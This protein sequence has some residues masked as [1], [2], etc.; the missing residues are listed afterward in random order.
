MG[1]FFSSLFNWYSQKEIE[2]AIIG[3]ENCGKT[4]LATQLQLNHVPS[5]ERIP[6]MTMNYKL[7]RRGHVLVKMMDLPGHR[8]C[9]QQWVNL[10][11]CCHA[12]IFMVD[13]TLLDHEESIEALK[14]VLPLLRSQSLPLL[15]V[16]NKVDLSSSVPLDQIMPSF[17]SLIGDDIPMVSCEVSAL[18]G[19]YVSKIITWVLQHAS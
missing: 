8:S 11:K 1:S 3:I 4:T 10:I 16:S 17:S 13:S 7:F 19:K 15:L 18:T 12:V 5:T 2:V 9:R 6:T 14:N